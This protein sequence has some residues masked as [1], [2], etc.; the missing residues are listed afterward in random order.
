MSTSN[1]YRASGVDIDRAEELVRQ[2]KPLA[3]RTRQPGVL[4][5]LGGFGGLFALPG[6]YADPV[7]VG[8]TDGVG[9]KLLL[10]NQQGAYH[11]LGIDLVAM[12]V[13]DL[14]ATG[15]KPLF[16]LDYLATGKLSLDTAK[17]TI[18]GIADGC[19]QAECA[20]LGGETAEMPGLYQNPQ[21][22]DLAGFAVGIAERANLQNPARVQP[23]DCLLGLAS[24]GAHANGFS[25]I[26]TI[27]ADS[28]AALKQPFGATTLEE[29]LLAPTRIYVRPLL[30]LLQACPV[31]A[32]CHITGGGLADN[33]PRV[34]PPGT[35]AIINR[36]AWRRPALFDW[37]AEKGQVTEDEMHRVF[38]CGIG[39][40]I[41]APPEARAASI[42]LLEG[43]GEQVFE[44][45][46]VEA[47]DGAPEVNFVN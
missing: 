46:R 34:L 11:G 2:I 8:T 25:L 33:L 30:S 44:I 18:A 17:A 47:G 26:R 40:V 12:C 31:H 3:A 6:G 13:N 36:S 16:F 35:R 7:L 22:C 37:L 5:E 39:F 14:V 27:L 19:C 29:A 1:R 10:A 23:G 9:T 32:L 45:G 20:L 41:C 15:A 21:D 42:A 38:N 4:G 28:A 43:A 24:S